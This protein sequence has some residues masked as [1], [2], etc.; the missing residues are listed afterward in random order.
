MSVVTIMVTVLTLVS[1]W[2]VVIVVNVLVDTL[3]YLTNMTVLEKVIFFI[4]IY[5][6]Q[7]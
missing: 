4:I 7:N 5:N 1:I 2:Q 6:L 3:S